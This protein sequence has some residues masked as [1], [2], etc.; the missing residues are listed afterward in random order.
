MLD[1][2]KQ[3]LLTAVTY[4]KDQKIRFLGKGS[5]T[6][7]DRANNLI[8]AEPAPAFPSSSIADMLVVDLSGQV[9]EGNG[10]PC[11]D[12]LTHLEIYR[13]FPTV[14]CVVH[15]HAMYTSAWAQA[16]RDIPMY[17]TGHL[18]FFKEAIPCTR[19]VTSAESES[20][21]E[22]SAGLCIAE[23]FQKKSI[24]PED[25]PAALLFQHGSYIWAPTAQ[26]AANRCVAL[27]Q[28][29][30]LAYLTEKINPE[31]T[32]LPRNIIGHSE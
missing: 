14:S 16:G 32:G 2:L 6:I 4:L 8:V 5:M 13:A 1:A 17:G 22:T 18:D 21:Y 26:E 7:V 20:G 27:E 11:T 29:A 3:D 30:M 31:I 9:I 15:S 12:F 19:A 24:S 25:T 10:T 28:I 23:T